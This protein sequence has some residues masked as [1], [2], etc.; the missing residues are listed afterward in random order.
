MNTQ[1]LHL[2]QRALDRKEGSSLEELT[3]ALQR[4]GYGNSSYQ[5]ALISCTKKSGVANLIVAEEL[6]TEELEQ[7]REQID[8]SIADPDYTL[9]SNYDI[10]Q[11]WIDF[12]TR[13]GPWAWAILSGMEEIPYK[14]P[15]EA[16]EEGWEPLSV[17]VVRG[18]PISFVFKKMVP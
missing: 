5:W 12:R 6:D 7:L 3:R 1:I 10:Q 15:E 18:I 4:S 13:E 8:F 17:E 14:T 9:I 16:M 11:K 2:L